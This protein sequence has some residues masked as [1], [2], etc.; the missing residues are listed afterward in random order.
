MNSLAIFDELDLAIDRLMTDPEAA[1]T[2]L[3]TGIAE[4]VEVVPDLRSLPRTDF[5]TR[6]RLELEWQASGRA[7]STAS[8]PAVRAER[9]QPDLDLLPTLSGNCKSLYPVRG[10]NF[11]VSVALHAAMFFLVGLGFVMVQG[12]SRVLQPRVTSAIRLDPYIPPAGSIPEHGGGGGGAHDKLG[13]TQGE[14]PRFAQEQFAPPAVTL[15]DPPPKLPVE[16]TLIGPPE[17]NLPANLA[18]DP[19]SYLLAPSSGAGVSGI[20]S[21]RGDGV[22]PGIG[23]GRGPGSGG[24]S[25]DG[26]YSTG[27]GVSAPRAI[28]DPEPDYSD[29]ARAAKYQGMVTLALVVR[30]DGRPTNL[31]V[32]RSL[33]M[34]LDE[35]ALEA[36]RTWRFEP[37]RK[38]G[39]PVAVQIEVE[40][41]FRLF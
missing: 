2:D 13:A 8:T 12:T 17:L 7:L 15:Q 14:A 38:D 21:G 11:A 25:G 32:A 39:R 6:L 36:V 29:E 4:L 41:D 40:V 34:G 28:Y 20:G 31:R 35:K 37:G 30:A 33:G 23:P 27:K 10:R 1:T 3:R 24:G 9:S 5:K 19:L 26:V 22:G 16:A 18:G